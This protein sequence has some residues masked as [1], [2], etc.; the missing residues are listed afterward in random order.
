MDTESLKA[1]LD[2]LVKDPSLAPANG[3]TFCN[4]GVYRISK[5]YSVPDFK[6]DENKN[7]PMA[8][9]M[10][11]ILAQSQ[12][13]QI[14]D[15]QAAND[16]ANAGKLVIAAHPYTGHGHVA[17]VYPSPEMFFSPSLNKLVPFLANIG[18]KVGVLP[19]SE[20]FPV[21]LGECL[22]YIYREAA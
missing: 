22:Y 15:G 6:L 21:A 5:L 3:E 12:D 9:A 8:D 18:Q 19:E 11:Q 4:I 7:P 13:F 16:A 2:A 1:A 20:D 17:T 14:C 10:C